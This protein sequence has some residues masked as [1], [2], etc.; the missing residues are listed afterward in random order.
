[1]KVTTPTTPLLDAHHVG[2]FMSCPI[3]NKPPL[4]IDQQIGK[5]SDR[6]LIIDNE[7]L[8]YHFLQ[9]NSY[10]R[11]SAYLYS[12]KQEGSEN[13]QRSL[14]FTDILN[15]YYFDK[16]LR[17]L[18]FDAIETIEISLRSILI[19]KLSTEFGA[20]WFEDPTLFK[21]EAIQKTILRT[22]QLETLEKKE[23]SHHTFIRHFYNNYDHT[24]LPPSW[25]VLEILSFGTLSYIFKHLAT[26][27]QKL[28]S[29]QYN[30]HYSVVASWM[31]SLTYTRNLCAHHSR[32]WNRSF[33]FRPI[34]E[35]THKAQIND[36][37]SFCAQDYVINR[38]L[39]K[40]NTNNQWRNDLLS[41]FKKY[42][43]IDKKRMGY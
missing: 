40:I 43:F 26:P 6:G 8:A 33:T 30:I 16:E 37:S 29:Q 13:Y 22:I 23:K 12:F 4:T 35:K 15:I 1:M 3:Y 24:T 5:L 2:F 11:F 42:P 20:N 32:L 14:K 41:L 17:T 34:I 9:H 39:S 27:A 28:V 19:N 31:H 18:C 7:D 10:Y 36:S 25:M 38:L 21:K